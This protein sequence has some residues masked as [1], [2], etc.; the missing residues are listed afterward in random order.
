MP[1]VQKDEHTRKIHE[2]ISIKR[3]LIILSVSFI[4]TLTVATFILTHIK[5]C[6]TQ[7][8]AEVE[9]LVNKFLNQKIDDLISQRERTGD[10]LRAKRAI[11]EFRVTNAGKSL[12]LRFKLILNSN[13]F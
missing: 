1:P 5:K 4:F 12:Q 10:N 8:D 3:D 11:H 2:K 13:L 7:S 9:R 6:Q